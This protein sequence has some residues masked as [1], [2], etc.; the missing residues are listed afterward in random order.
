MDAAEIAAV[1]TFKFA[2]AV[3]ARFCLSRLA[4]M[5]PSNVMKKVNELKRK[6]TEGNEKGWSS[7]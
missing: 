2:G 4:N 5:P 3:R 7:R 6:P 1:G